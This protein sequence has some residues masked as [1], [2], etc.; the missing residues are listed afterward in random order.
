[1]RRQVPPFHRLRNPGN[2][3]GLMILYEMCDDKIPLQSGKAS[4]RM[5]ENVRSLV[6]GEAVS[7]WTMQTVSPIQRSLPQTQRASPLPICITLHSLQRAGLLCSVPPR[8]CRTQQ[9]LYSTFGHCRAK[10]SGSRLSSRWQT[11]DPLPAEARLLRYQC[12]ITSH[13]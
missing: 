10:D 9:R 11:A 2:L 5:C 12:S 13:H 1:M 8:S 7:A 4:S 3:S 6:G